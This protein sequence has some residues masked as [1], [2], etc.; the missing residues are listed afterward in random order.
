[1]ANEDKDVS[2]LSLEEIQLELLTI[3]KTA[4]SWLSVNDIRLSRM[5]PFLEPFA[6]RVLFL[7]ATILILIY[8]VPIMSTFRSMLPNLSGQQASRFVRARTGNSIFRL[9]RLSILPLG[10]RKK[11]LMAFMRAIYGL[12]CFRLTPSPILTP[13]TKNP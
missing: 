8:R 10:L 4:Q 1:M 11:I 3:L 12:M 2:Y 7:G 5:A 6:I 9:L 13:S